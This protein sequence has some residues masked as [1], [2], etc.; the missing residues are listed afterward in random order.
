MNK[1]KIVVILLSLVFLIY[2]I[3]RLVV[4]PILEKSMNKVEPEE[5]L[6]VSDGTR[7]VHN[8]LLI[9]DWH[10]DSTLWARDLG[11]LESYGHVDIPRLQ[12]GNVALQMFTTVTKSPDGLN[13][14]E[15]KADAPDNITK[16][17]IV[18]GWP[19]ST[20]SS[21]KARALFQAQKLHRLAESHPDD[22]MLVDSQAALET[23]LQKRQ[24]NP[25]FVG[26]LIGTEGSHAL[27]G[28]LNNIQVLFDNGFRM[29]SLQH[30]FDNKLGGSLHG[31]SNAGLTEFG[32]QAVQI[33]QQMDI[34]VDVS[35]SS[36]QTVKDVLA[37]SQA[38][39][40]VSHTGLNGHCNTKRN[41]DDE[42]MV[43]I[44]KGGGLIAIG[45][46]DEAVCGKHPND[47]ADA[48]I[49]GIGLLGEDH[50]SLGSDY[51]GGVPVGFDTSDLALITQALIEKGVEQTAIAKVMGGNMLRFLQQE[52]PKL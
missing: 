43:D 26:G 35:H 46:W 36:H 51:D 11:E 5:Q 17:A 2:V 37:I 29:M 7:L 28:D 41:I 32:K 9:G 23:L 16:A 40:V 10:A 38:P 13:Y 22:F 20:L 49:Y 3:V 1:T 33:M 19:L 52:L 34:I 47:I 6:T 4:P 8:A 30:F 18:Q 24:T 15:N 14:E 27:D 50:L 42:L 12:K 21:L 39:L 45:Y 25:R 44:A 31:T 48:I